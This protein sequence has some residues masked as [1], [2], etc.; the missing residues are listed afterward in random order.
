M[1]HHGVLHC[2]HPRG[3][4]RRRVHATPKRRSALCF[5]AR[6][7]HLR[8]RTRLRGGRVPSARGERRRLHDSGGVLRR[9][10]H[11]GRVCGAFGVHALMRR[12]HLT[13]LL[14]ASIASLG[15]G[16]VGYEAHRDAGPVDA[17]PAP[18]DS[19]ADAALEDGGDADAARC[20]AGG[21]CDFTCREASCDYEC[22][23]GATCAVDCSAGTCSIECAAGS[24]CEITCGRGGSCSCGRGPACTNVCTATG[25]CIIDS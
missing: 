17:A 19:A 8:G 25:D 10:L 4:E 3:D 12:S 21:S 2:A 1:P 14:I 16:R 15:C 9:R 23:P 7:S 18:V 5:A 6:R 11:V 13:A 22:P 24:I 20:V